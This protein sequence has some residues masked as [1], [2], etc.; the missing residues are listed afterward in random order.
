[1]LGVKQSEVLMNQFISLLALQEPKLPF[2]TSFKSNQLKIKI[3]AHS[4]MS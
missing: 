4:T 3:T 2:Y 1:M